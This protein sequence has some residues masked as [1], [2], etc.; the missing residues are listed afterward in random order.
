M[1]S[2]ALTIVEVSDTTMVKNGKMPV[3]KSKKK[4]FNERISNGKAFD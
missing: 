2:I 1:G 4:Q 3:P